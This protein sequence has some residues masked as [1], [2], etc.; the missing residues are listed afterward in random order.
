MAGAETAKGG[1]SKAE[2]AQHKYNF[3]L[4]RLKWEHRRF[5][6]SLVG[7]L[8]TLGG[9]FL[10][11]QQSIAAREESQKATLETQLSVKFFDLKPDERAAFVENLKQYGWVDTSFVAKLESSLPAANATYNAR[12]KAA[13]GDDAE[14]LPDEFLK[15]L[16][17]LVSDDAKKRRGAR[18]RLADLLVD[19][20]ECPPGS[21]LARLDDYLRTDSLSTSQSYRTAL[22]IAVA[23]SRIEGSLGKPQSAFATIFAEPAMTDRFRAKLADM[24]ERYK[25]PAL[26]SA[27]AA[28]LAKFG[29]APG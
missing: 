29:S 3:D 18:D 16:E 17:Q 12:E 11:F 19:P 13:L 20:V 8:I 14:T 6:L 15:T 4:Q 7:L 9:I 22:G 2:L 23:I 21:C 24:V 25:E 5:W 27:A 1:L 28:A 26:N 10:G